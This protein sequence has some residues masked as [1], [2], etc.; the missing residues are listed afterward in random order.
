[1]KLRLLKQ[2]NNVLLYCP[3]GTIIKP[4]EEDLIRL[5]TSFSKPQHFK[6]DAGRWSVNMAGMEDAAGETL[7]YVDDTYKLIILDEQ[8]FVGLFKPETKYISVSEYATLYGKCRATV[9]NL[10][11]A[12]KLPGA[13]KTSSGWLIPEGTP[14]PKDGRVG[15]TAK[16]E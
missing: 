3:N 11:V 9:K 1:M 7:A 10:C 5:L 16:K 4:T 2:K 13:Y 8:A 6:G 12:G 15:R 14:Y